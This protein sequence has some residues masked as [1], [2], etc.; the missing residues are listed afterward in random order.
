MTN[1]TDTNDANDSNDSNGTLTRR[2]TRTVL[3]AATM[4][5]AAV[6]GLLL[7][8]TPPS[9]ARKRRSARSDRT[10]KRPGPTSSRPW[11]LRPSSF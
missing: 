9:P 4:G 10:P 2:G 1:G 6:F 3:P 5:T 8:G 11:A 7:V